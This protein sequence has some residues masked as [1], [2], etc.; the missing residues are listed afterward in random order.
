MDN[1][2]TAMAILTAGTGS[3]FSSLSDTRKGVLA[4][5]AAVVMGFAIGTTTVSQIG[6]PARVEAL[7]TTVLGHGARLNTVEADDRTAQRE[8]DYI[9]RAVQWQ[10]CA[11]EAQNDEVDLKRTCGDKPTYG[12]GR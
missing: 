11:I 5:L 6:L 4:L 3:W 8:R 7:E 9:L 2:F 1:P 10:N 12:F